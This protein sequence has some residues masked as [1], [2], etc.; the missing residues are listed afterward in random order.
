MKK[1]KK[2]EGKGNWAGGLFIGN[3]ERA[4]ATYANDLFWMSLLCLQ[5]FGGIFPVIECRFPKS[6]KLEKQAR[7]SSGYG[8]ASIGTSRRLRYILL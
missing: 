2:K 6:R 8:F 4:W 1:K 5:T 7:I 3:L